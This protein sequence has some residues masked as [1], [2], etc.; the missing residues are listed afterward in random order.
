MGINELQSID[1][2]IALLESLDEIT[3]EIQQFNDALSTYT[4]ANIVDFLTDDTSG[5][6][7]LGHLKDALFK[8]SSTAEKYYKPLA[9]A[10]GKLSTISS[11]F[12]TI[13][14]TIKLATTNDTASAA[15]QLRSLNTILS[16]MTTVA[17]VLTR[18]G[19]V[20]PAIGA[21]F[22]LYGEAIES[23]AIVIDLIEKRVAEQ[24]EAMR[25][26]K[27]E[28]PQVELDAIARANAAILEDEKWQAMTAE[29]DQMI[30]GLIMR[31][32]AIIAA[33]HAENL[34]DAYKL[35]AED[36]RDVLKK[37]LDITMPF[38]GW[39]DKNTLN[40]ETFISIIEWSDTMLSLIVSENDIIIK[41][42]DAGNTAAANAAL[43]K[44]KNM[45]IAR[46]AVLKL[47]RPLLNSVSDYLQEEEFPVADQE[48]I[49]S[50]SMSA[51]QAKRIKTGVVIGGIL[52]AM[53]GIGSLTGLI[54]PEA[55]QVA[56][57][58]EPA[59]S[60]NSP[61][62][63]PA[64]TASPTQLPTPIASL[65]DLRSQLGQLT[66]S[67]VGETLLNELAPGLFGQFA[68]YQFGSGN[69][70][71]HSDGLQ[72]KAATNA[73][74]IISIVNFNL[75]LDQYAIDRLFTNTDYPCGPG[76][77]GYTVCGQAPFPAGAAI[78]IGVIYDDDIAIQDPQNIYQYGFVFDSDGDET[79]NY[80]A[81]ERFPNDF[82]DGTDLFYVLAY[83]PANGWELTST[84][85]RG[86]RKQIA[87]GAR[88]II[89]GNTIIMVIPAGEISL[90]RPLFRLTAFRHT[91]DYGINPPHDWDAD[92]VPPVDEPLLLFGE[93]LINIAVE[94]SPRE[95]ARLLNLDRIHDFYASYNDAFA[96]Q[97]TDLLF[98]LL[99]PAVFELY[100]EDACRS[101]LEIVI[102]NTISVEAL[103]VNA[104]GPWTY[105]QDNADIQIENTYTIEIRVTLPDFSTQTQATHLAVLEDGTIT[106]F[107]DCGDPLQ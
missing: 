65:T 2:E 54:G 58:Q 16:G 40:H 18:V 45:T 93:I 53:Y 74:D 47:L 17:K 8:F 56:V 29:L 39:S 85:V 52:I 36:Y 91:G 3:Q 63:F 99:H 95:P 27:G 107:T 19:S 55:S 35:V 51:N 32:H 4:G 70:V 15:D 67:L 25:I 90:E 86:E 11:L 26:A 94:G 82:F 83:T 79:N 28:T 21:F 5:K 50:S 38:G 81:S 89:N 10:S 104:F 31:R 100:G 9:D 44:V 101:Y 6:Y 1:A 102:V 34:S 73:T 42:R 30:S 61:T 23:A 76:E 13:N 92:V 106:W 41:L 68:G 84:D 57:P 96:R 48:P 66:N 80:A 105:D 60:V 46:D 14:E 98:S 20:N 72:T 78:V 59:L 24:K 97:D 71:S 22:I 64:S 43:E 62:L 12:T 103:S 88:A 75:A 49:S 33:R 7:M 77:Y 87:T 69:M 37:I